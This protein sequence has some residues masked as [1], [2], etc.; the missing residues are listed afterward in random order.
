MP[1]ARERRIAVPTMVLQCVSA[2]GIDASGRAVWSE[3]LECDVPARTGDRLGSGA[4]PA[5][6]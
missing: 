4:A 5:P 2:H 3:F 6:A 1:G